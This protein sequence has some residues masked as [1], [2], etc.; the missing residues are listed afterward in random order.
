MSSNLP[1]LPRF[2]QYQEASG[3]GHQYPPAVAG[4]TPGEWFLSAMLLLLTCI[5]TTFAGI[6]YIVGDVGFFAVARLILSKPHTILQGLS[7]SIPLIVILLAHEIGHFWACRYYGVRCTPPYFIPAPISIAGTL[8]AFIKIKSPF[9]NRRA[10]FDIGI[11]GPAAG[12]IFLLPVLWIGI[13]LSTTI[14]KGSLG[15]GTLAFGEPLI[16][17]FLGWLVIGYTPATQ[18]MMAHPMA[19]AA[20]FGLL[21]TSLNLLPI[22]Q[23]DGG[24]IAYAIWGPMAQ[25]KISITAVLA[26]IL[27]SFWSWPM[28]SYL[29]F[30]LLLLILGA[31]VRFYHP[32]PIS[33]YEALGPGRKILGIVAMLIFVLT[34]IPVPISLV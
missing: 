19:M 31:R 18:D 6:F 28:P 9:Q 23:L 33:D 16:F 22:W 14:P 26:L 8:G 20:W 5:T 34:F 25:R 17:K 11:A 21:A 1:E 12:F 15:A 10:L 24:H 3:A 32:A 30:S 4:P 7:F 27:L 29:L 13:S 2:I